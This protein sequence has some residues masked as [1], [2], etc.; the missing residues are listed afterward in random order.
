MARVV[1][2]EDEITV[3]SANGMV[4]RQKVKSI[5]ATGRVTRG[6]HFM[7]VVKG[8]SVASLARISAAD[9]QES[10]KDNGD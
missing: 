5:P 3:I 6:I 9:Q 4:L 10:G 1:Q 7:D 2:E 8:D